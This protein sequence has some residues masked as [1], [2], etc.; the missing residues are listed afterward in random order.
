VQVNVC[1]QR[2]TG[3][4]TFMTILAEW[5]YRHKI[6]LY[7]NYKLMFPYK[8]INIDMLT[9]YEIEKS[10]L[11]LIDEVYLLFESAESRTLF[12]RLMSYFFW[13][14][15]K[16]YVDIAI[17]Y[18]YNT[19]VDPKIRSGA[20]MWVICNSIPPLSRHA[21]YFLWSFRIPKETT[22]SPFYDINDLETVYEVLIPT[23]SLK[24]I[25]KLFDTDELQP[26]HEILESK[27]KG[28]YE[29]RRKIRNE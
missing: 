27:Y 22:L 3:K 15:R 16:R 10:A 18:Q 23:E 25:W 1:G 24:P 17:S 9:N 14:S 7:A 12:N 2:G 4:S 28:S 21:D 29:L 8:K 13:Q 26:I 19:S 11:I 6:P 5:A 20:D